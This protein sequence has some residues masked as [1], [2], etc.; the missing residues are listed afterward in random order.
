VVVN[1]EINNILSKR[2]LS[3]WLMTALLE[4]ETNSASDNMIYIYSSNQIV[5]CPYR[6]SQNKA[7]MI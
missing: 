1:F 4:I 6:K 5:K 2:H 7:R 3:S